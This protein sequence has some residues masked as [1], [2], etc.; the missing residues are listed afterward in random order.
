MKPR[1][2]RHPFSL[3]AMSLLVALVLGLFGFA[4]A[5][6]QS[7]PPGG[8]TAPPDGG[9]LGTASPFAWHMAERAEL[10]WGEYRQKSHRYDNDYV[11][12]KGFEVG[13]DACKSNLA[14]NL[15]P[16]RYQWRISNA[17]TGYVHQAATTGCTFD[18]TTKPALPKLAQGE[19]SVRLTLSFAGGTTRSGTGI[20]NVKDLLIV[21]LGDSNAAGEGNPHRSDDDVPAPSSREWWDMRCHRS[22][23][24]AAARAADEVETRDPHTSVTFLSFGCSGAEIID[25]LVR[26]YRGIDPQDGIS[27]APP[28][29][30]NLMRHICGDW[31]DEEK[32]TGACYT[33]PRQIDALWLMIGINDIGFSSIL[34]VCAGLKKLENIDVRDVLAPWALYDIYKQDDITWEQI[35]NITIDS[36]TGIAD[37]FVD[38]LWGKTCDETLGPLLERNFAALRADF[39]LLAGFLKGKA[40]SYARYPKDIRADIARL[41]GN[42][43]P[44]MTTVLKSAPVYVVSYPADLFS[45]KSGYRNGCGLFA[46]LATRIDH[47][48]AEWLYDQGVQLNK[49]VESA[50]KLHRWH[51]VDG[52]VKAFRGHGYCAG[53]ASWHVGLLDS[54]YQQGD[55]YGT[56]HPNHDGHKATAG[57][58]IATYDAP[59]P[60][61]ALKTGIRIDVDAVTITAPGAVNPETQLSINVTE[62]LW[63]RFP[64]WVRQTP[65]KVNQRVKFAP[66]QFV[67][68]VRLADDDNFHLKAFSKVNLGL[69]PNLGS[70]CTPSGGPCSI[71]NI[72]E[73]IT[74]RLYDR[75][76]GFGSESPDCRVIG[77][78][79]YV[80]ELTCKIVVQA[81]E[82]SLTLEYR[83]TIT[84][85]TGPV[86]LPDNGG[87]LAQSGATVAP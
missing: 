80:K 42:L 50:G 16:T 86:V 15:H 24:S 2:V 78:S 70:G 28:Q 46:T 26:E 7:L 69:T 48:E 36:L 67:F 13:L 39:D 19:Y 52:V 55:L 14:G 76:N 40:T 64:N 71:P 37:E 73:L 23:W 45:N 18:R 43:P 22:S 61:W 1:L 58:I 12:P 3:V 10:G 35:G 68:Q 30:L 85:L 8:P 5:Q 82:A 66:G 75:R 65:V 49:Q 9:V 32:A 56:V 54:I 74:G 25:G 31:A 81:A 72:A 77:G 27:E 29:L 63:P 34:K 44:A 11:N 17:A 60:D 87:G 79:R 57:R 84:D 51:Y 21:S 53:D 41:Y 83:I 59:K 20:I 62:D 6:A 4:P 47:D 38:I 33:R